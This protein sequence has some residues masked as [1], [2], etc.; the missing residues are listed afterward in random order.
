MV[1][2]AERPEATVDGGLGPGDDQ[3]PDASIIAQGISAHLAGLASSGAVDVD[4]HRRGVR[5]TPTGAAVV[6]AGRA[7]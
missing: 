6:D 5:G 4:V 2:V 7:A 3:S 1:G